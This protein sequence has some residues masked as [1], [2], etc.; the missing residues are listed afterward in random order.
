MISCY[1]LLRNYAKKPHFGSANN[2]QSLTFMHVAQIK[3]KW[4]L[5]CGWKTSLKCALLIQPVRLTVS[6][7]ANKKWSVPATASL[8]NL[9]SLTSV[10][11]V[12]LF[13][14]MK[15]FSCHLIKVCLRL[16]LHLSV[17]LLLAVKF[18]IESWILLQ[19]W[20]SRQRGCRGVQ[21]YE[22]LS[23]LVWLPFAICLLW[24]FILQEH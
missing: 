21:L 13:P 15:G 4:N 9:L 6:F 20:Y 8:Q 22:S 18:G 17:F 12:W 23:A 7:Q 24:E 5:K 11:H 3:C 2:T 10:V 14:E 19:L 1:N 16:L